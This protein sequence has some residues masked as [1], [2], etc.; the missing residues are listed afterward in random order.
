[1]TTKSLPNFKSI[2][3]ILSSVQDIL[4]NKVVKTLLETPLLSSLFV[5]DFAILLFLRPPVLFSLIML[6]GL[7]GLA[8]YFGQKLALFK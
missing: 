5:T 8:M 7:V 2:T 1:M 6:G 4:I 3:A